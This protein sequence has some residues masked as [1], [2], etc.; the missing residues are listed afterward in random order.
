[1]TELLLRTVGVT[2]VEDTLEGT[3]LL[4]FSPEFLASNSDEKAEDP[5]RRE[6]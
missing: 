2:T 3:F 6:N 1:V 5:S 4:A